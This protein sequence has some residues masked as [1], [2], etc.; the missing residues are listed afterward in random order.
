MMHI[1]EAK[2]DQTIYHVV[3]VMSIFTNWPWVESDANY[4]IVCRLLHFMHMIKTK[5]PHLT[6]GRGGGGVLIF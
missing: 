3:Q 4:M 6:P 2:F 5:K 1:N